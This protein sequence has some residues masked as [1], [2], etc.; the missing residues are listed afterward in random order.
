MK[1]Q[2]YL[3]EHPQQIPN[4]DG[5]EVD[6]VVKACRS[7]LNDKTATLVKKF[8]D[9]TGLYAVQTKSNAG[10]YFLCTLP[11]TI[12]YVVKYEPVRMHSA[13]LP[14]QSGIRQ[15]LIKRLEGASPYAA[16]IGADIFWN[17]LLP[18]CGCLLSDS[19]QTSNGRTFWEYRIKEA[20]ETNRTVRMIDTNAVSFVDIATIAQ[21]K[22]LSPQIWGPS[23]WFQRI[24][25]AIYW[26]QTKTK[27]YW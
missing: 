7:A 14:Q 18:K 5:G 23:R 8:D 25:L 24:I 26:K 6:V 13:L 20:L 22:S 12:E 9:T 4:L 21:L 17:F 19:Q 27:I 1:F 11:S 10:L 3:I 15:V 16:G 2:Q